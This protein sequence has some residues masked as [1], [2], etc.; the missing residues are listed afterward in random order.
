MAVHRVI[1]AGLMAVDIHAVS[2]DLLQ[3]RVAPA[4]GDAQLCAGFHHPQAGDL[5]AGVVR[6]R[7]GNQAVEHRV[8][9]DLPP[10]ADVRVLRALTGVFKG[11]GVPVVD[12][13]FAGRLEVR[14]QPN[15]PAKDRYP[16]QQQSTMPHPCGCT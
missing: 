6:V 13:G 8:G 5:Q 12:P 1:P 16:K 7:L 9:E 2:G 4:L 14:T 15:A 10:L 3:L 11:R